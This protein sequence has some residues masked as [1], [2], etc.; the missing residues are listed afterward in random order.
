MVISARK[1]AGA[2][3]AISFASS[4]CG[5]H[6]HVGLNAPPAAASLQERGSAYEQLKPL[7]M[8]ETHTTYYKGGAVMGASR[9][10]D[11]LQLSDGRRVYH[12][13]D[14][15]AVVPPDSPSATA[16]REAASKASAAS[17]FS[18]I[19]WIAFTLGGV[20]MISPFLSGDTGN[21]D[22]TPVLVG[23]GIMLAGLPFTS[24]PGASVAR[25]TTRRR[26]PSKPT[27]RPSEKRLHLCARDNQLVDCD[28]PVVAPPAPAPPGASPPPAA[29]PAAPPP[30]APSDPPMEAVPPPTQLPDSP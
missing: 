5:G 9:T 19:Y 22:M 10:T 23:G 20:V 2:V 17:T 28:A 30:T 4:A 11:Y 8:H 21:F 24:S 6:P 13:D 27:N 16:A 29:P 1:L 3:V 25:R 18:A 12:A 15:L 26:R 7:S 14:L